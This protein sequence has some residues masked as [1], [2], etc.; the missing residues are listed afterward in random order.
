MAVQ[1]LL[2]DE[3]PETGFRMKQYLQDNVNQTVLCSLLSARQLS[4]QAELYHPDMVIVDAGIK[5]RDWVA[6]CYD[7]NLW[8]PETCTIIVSNNIENKFSSF[9]SI[10][11]I[12]MVLDKTKDLDTIC[13][14]IESTTGS[15]A[16]FKAVG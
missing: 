4:D 5:T 10:P 9:N 11:G 16:V 7:L 2:V 14:L 8:F 1:I 3:H 12:Y 6:L 15:H 13:D